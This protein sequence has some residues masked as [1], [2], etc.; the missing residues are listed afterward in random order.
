MYSKSLHHMKRRYTWGKTTVSTGGSTLMTGLT[1]SSSF[2]TTSNPSSPIF[3]HTTILPLP[4]HP[5]GPP[6]IVHWIYT[7]LGP[8]RAMMK[9]FIRPYKRVQPTSMLQPLPRDSKSRMQ[10][11]I[12]ITLFSTPPYKGCMGITFRNWRGWKNFMTLT[13]SWALQEDSDSELLY[14]LVSSPLHVTRLYLSCIFIPTS[15]LRSMS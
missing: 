11:S 1:F 3:S 13:T 15:S 4:T 8:A 6:A 10:L 2:P 7:T 5:I 14:N 9:S 12:P